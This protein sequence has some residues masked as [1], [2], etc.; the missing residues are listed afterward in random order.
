MTQSQNAINSHF[1][2]S[3]PFVGL[4]SE[5][6]DS[7][8]KFLFMAP[9]HSVSV[10]V[11]FFCLSKGYGPDISLA[12]LSDPNLDLSPYPSSLLMQHG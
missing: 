9:W 3:K 1:P 6:I 5:F 10:S 7:G 8:H 2:N 4:E 11:S 12:D